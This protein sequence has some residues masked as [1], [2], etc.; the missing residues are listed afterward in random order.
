MK[1]GVYRNET[2]LMYIDYLDYKKK[3]KLY[4]FSRSKRTGLEKVI[5][6]DIGVTYEKEVSEDDLDFAYELRFRAE[7]F[8]HAFK[9]MSS[10]DKRRLEDGII[11][12]STFDRD[13][14]DLL[15]F[16]S[17]DQFLLYKDVQM[18]DIDRLIEVKVPILKFKGM[19]EIET[20]IPKDKI[21]E[22]INNKLE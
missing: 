5:N 4:L 7:Y 13:I 21:A 15:E 11:A 19:E 20:E 10:I 17:Y 12:L 1:Y 6:D 22:Y 16:D 3:E 2:Y 18:D 8:G 14:G 9:V